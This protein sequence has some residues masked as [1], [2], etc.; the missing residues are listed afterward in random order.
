MTS[1]KGKMPVGIAHHNFKHGLS[2]SKEFFIW[3][4]MHQRCYRP[5]VRSYHRYG[6]RGIRICDEWREDFAAFLAYVGKA[7]SRAHSIDR[8]DNNGHYEPGNVWWTTAK[9]QARNST[10]AR[11][12]T[13]DGRTMCIAEWSEVTGIKAVTLRRRLR[14]GW[15]IERTLTTPV[16]A[17][18][19]P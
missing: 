7:P 1:R 4:S 19:R 16:M 11:P 10:A 5:S 15:S 12:I 14:Y 8:K 2:S 17:T 6:G 18:T 13:F 9:P 3:Y